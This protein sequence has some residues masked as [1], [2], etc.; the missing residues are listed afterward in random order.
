ML[1]GE[2]AWNNLMLSYYL[3]VPAKVTITDSEL[4]N[5]QPKPESPTEIA[6][7]KA[8]WRIFLQ[9]LP[10]N[11]VSFGQVLM[12][13]FQTLDT[14]NPS[15]SNVRQLSSFPDFQVKKTTFVEPCH[16]ILVVSVSPKDIH[17]RR[18]N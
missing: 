2:A 7:F 12:T 3:M 5:I 8:K 10:V 4:K 18:P 14:F 6:K 9:L 17:H 15:H 13:G 16:L 11:N 1:V